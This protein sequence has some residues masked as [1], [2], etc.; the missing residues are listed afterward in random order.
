MGHWKPAQW[1]N[2]HDKLVDYRAW[3]PEPIA[4]LTFPV[5]GAFQTAADVH[6][7]EIAACVRQTGG[8]A[9][10]WFLN[11][12]EG[13]ASTTIEGI[14][15]SAP[16]VARTLF[17]GEGD[18]PEL[19]AVSNL[20]ALKQAL[21]IGASGELPEVDHILGIHEALTRKLPGYRGFPG[22]LR[23]EQNWLLARTVTDDERETYGPAGPG[24]AFVPPVPD[25]VQRALLDL[26]VFCQRTDMNPIVQAAIA[27]AR[28]EEIHPFS[29]GNG[30]TGRALV[31]MLW[32]RRGLVSET[33]TV[34]LSAIFA[35]QR[36]RYI[37]A[38]DAF[39]SEESLSTNEAATRPIIS[40]FI[41]ASKAAV[42]RAHEVRRDLVA[43]IDEW[44]ALLSFRRGSLGLRMLEGL[45]QRPV[46]NIASLAEAYGS[47]E[48]QAR[49]V[50][51]ELVSTGV[52]V[53]DEEDKDTYLARR[54]LDTFND[55]FK[56]TIGVYRPSSVEPSGEHPQPTTSSG[57]T[58]ARRRYVPCGEPM[59]RSQARCVLQ[60]GHAGHHRSKPPWI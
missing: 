6:E 21:E 14:Y 55:I 13:S 31:H 33:S 40:V 57:P 27:H 25:D 28:F 22:F 41:D 2:K 3:S 58:T 1:R 53:P 15:P 39:H 10:D 9:C 30:R 59:P 8:F 38:L 37:A 7:Q 45:V 35:A 29:D 4:E 16:D 42:E 19:A 48:R 34:P 32:A 5:D 11:T 54:L 60:Q 47:S 26:A 36:D 24:V 56:D 12:A 17:T 44:K 50:L 52:L 51:N 46:C 43:L 20:A 49:R 23:R 18:R